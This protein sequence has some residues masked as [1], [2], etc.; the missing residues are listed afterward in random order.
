MSNLALYRTM[1]RSSVANSAIR[2]FFSLSTSVSMI[3]IVRLLG[4]HEFGK[5][6]YILQLA[7][8]IGLVLSWGASTTLGKFLPEMKEERDQALLSSQLLEWITLSVTI[9]AVGFLLY[10]ALFPKGVPAEL[11]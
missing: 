3:F 8:T 7:V 2:L 1:F 10:A 9:F 11:A 6:S 4:P 5:L